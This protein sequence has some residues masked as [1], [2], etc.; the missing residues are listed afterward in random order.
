MNRFALAFFHF[1]SP[2]SA[3]EA[4]IRRD[5]KWCHQ[6]TS[7]H[8]EEH[9]LGFWGQMRTMKHNILLQMMK[10]F[11]KSSV[12]DGSDDPCHPLACLE[13]S[14]SLVTSCS[15]GTRQ[16]FCFI[17]QKCVTHT[18]HSRAAYARVFTERRSWVYFRYARPPRVATTHH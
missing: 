2:R 11:L 12:K 6:K 5:G 13:P 14:E 9:S 17:R 10:V 8:R 16:E 3:E 4:T 15:R 18:G 7:P 1:I